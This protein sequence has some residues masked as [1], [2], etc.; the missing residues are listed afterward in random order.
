VLLVHNPA[1]VDS[2]TTLPD[3]RRPPLTRRHVFAS[4]SMGLLLVLNLAR[5]FPKDA[6]MDWWYM[7]PVTSA[8]ISIIDGER[9]MA[10]IENRG[11]KSLDAFRFEITIDGRVMESGWRDDCCF[12][13][14]TGLWPLLPHA[15]KRIP[16]RPVNGGISVTRPAAHI[17]L[18]VFD[19]GSYEGRLSEFRQ[20]VKQ[21]AFV[22]DDAIYWASAIDRAKDTAFEARFNI[23]SRV[24]EDR[25][26][27]AKLGRQADDA[28]GIPNL[29][30]AA[31]TNPEA[32]ASVAATTKTN[33]AAAELALRMRIAAAER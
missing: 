2:I 17:T 28:L 24:Y 29:V 25:S 18:A 26:H 5:V 22:A 12:G 6:V 27:A 16:L 31:R 32:Y 13:V 7:R 19:D 1:I 10:I 3:E 21:R 11:D 14:S 30:F 15:S 4:V 20:L 33:L 8:A 9:P 23:F